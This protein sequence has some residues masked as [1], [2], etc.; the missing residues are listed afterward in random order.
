MKTIK[1]KWY[2]VDEKLP[3]DGQNVICKHLHGV[4]ETTF[5]KQN[6]SFS[7]PYYGQT[8]G[9]DFEQVTHWTEFPKFEL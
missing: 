5:F 4:N 9:Y 8:C 3:D 6:K 7:E 1:Y 2:S